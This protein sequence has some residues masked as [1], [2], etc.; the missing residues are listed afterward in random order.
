[1]KNKIIILSQILFVLTS[2]GAVNT[3]NKH[4]SIE[5]SISPSF[6][7]YSET[8]AN[9]LMVTNENSQFEYVDEVADPA[10]VR[11]YENGYIYA[12]ATNQVVLR[13]S[14]GC[15]YEK[16]NRKALNKAPTWG[17]EVYPDTTSFGVWAPDVIKIGDKW[18]YYYSLSNWM[19]CVGIGYAIST[20][21][22]EP[23]IDQGKLFTYLEIGID[24]VIDPHV[25]VEG[26]KVYMT[27]GSFCGLYV[28]ELTSDG[29][30]LK[31]GVETQKEEK[32]LV[33][34]R[35]GGWDSA[36]YEASYVLKKDDY[37]YYFGSAG[38]CCNGQKST[39]RVLVGKSKSIKGPYLDSTG[40]SLTE[41]GNG[42]TYGD[43]CLWGGESE[44][45]KVY[46][47]GHNSVFVDDKNDYWLIYHAYTEKDHYRTRHL[48]MDKLLWDEKGY[49]YVENK[50]P[51]FE[52]EKEGPSF[53]I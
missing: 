34:G 17:Q 40:H 16:L 30:A 51:S 6:E 2:C 21:L 13:S 9:P 19:Q 50:I 22:D 5:D 45:K 1:M 44:S 24:N 48:M 32:V 10:V 43:I 4:S 8:Y 35:E 11:D 18:I 23:F 14:D 36:T 47:P 31:G 26:D 39:Y 53:V 52:E 7:Y 15:T 20:S 37:Y 28:L 3:S 29:M 12:F 46:G 33:A 42:I 38:S 49:P 27:C 25:F 41:S